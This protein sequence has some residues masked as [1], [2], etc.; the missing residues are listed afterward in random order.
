MIIEKSY[1]GINLSKC[2]TVGFYKVQIFLFLFIPFFCFGQNEPQYD[3]VTVFLKVPGI[4]GAD[5]PALIK[6][7]VAYLSISDVFTLLKIKNNISSRLDSLSGFFINPQDEYL[8]DKVKNQIIF[9]KKKIEL[10]SDDLIITETTLYMKT[11]LFGEVFGLNCQFNIRN[12]TIDLTTKL[13]LPTI[14]EMKMEQMRENLKR[15]RGEI[16]TD[17]TIGRSYPLFKFGM[18]DWIIN[19]SQQQGMSPSTQL[20]F[21]LGSMVA[22]G[23]MNMGLNYDQTNRF[24]LRQQ[25]YLW[26]YANNE[27][28]A[29]RQVLIGKML[30]QTI[31]SL[32]GS[33]VGIQLNNTPTV[34]RRSFGTYNLTDVTEPGWLVELYINN[35]LVDYVKA[36]A[37]GF[38]KFEVPLVY[39]NS[40]LKVRM[41]GPWG[42]IREKI[43]NANI[44]FNFLPQGELE[45]VTTA[46]VVE[47]QPNTK[48]SRTNVTYG[49]NHRISIGGGYEYFSS[50][51]IEN[52][53]P[54]VSS[55]IRVDN[56]LMVSGEYVLGTRLKSTLS[57]RLPS[58]L[59]L[60]LDYTGYEKDQK[61]IT[62]APIQE[63]G[64]SISIPTQGKKISTY[65]MLYLSQ[66]IYSNSQSTNALF[67]FSANLH[68]VSSNVT[69]SLTYLDTKHIN[70]TSNVSLSFLL[71]KRFLLRPSAQYDY[72]QRKWMSMKWQLDKPLF[73]KGYLNISYSRDFIN[74]VNN[75]IEIGL[76]YDCSFMQ[77]TFTSRINKNSSLYT[78]SANGSLLFDHKTHY[79]RASNNSMVGRAGLTFYAFLD[80]NGNGKRDNNEPKVFGLSLRVNG[81]RIL[82]HDK[83]STIRVIDLIPYTSY[84]VELNN[85]SFQNIA[86]KVK[87]AALTVYADPNQFKTIEIPVDVMSEATGTVSLKSKNGSKGLGRVYV[88][89]YRNDGSLFGRILTEGDGYYS[90]MGLKPGNYIARMDSSQLAKIKMTVSPEFKAFTVKSSK[91]GDFIEG[92]DFTLQSTVKDTTE[93]V[94]PK[95]KSI[96]I[97]PPTGR[98]ANIINYAMNTV[99][100]AEVVTSQNGQKRINATTLTQNVK[101]LPVSGRAD[102]SN[103]LT[104]YQNYQYSIESKQ[105]YS[106]QMGSYIFDA[107]ALAAQRKITAATGLPVV[108]V[109][110]DGF[111][112]LWID[113]FA[114]RKMAERFLKR[115][116]KMGFH[117]SYIIRGNKDITILANE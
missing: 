84:L 99:K 16:K 73:G 94:A 102:L 13:E 96:K 49:L 10:K 92:L 62:Y 19:T 29:L 81:G 65:S 30:Q 95:S 17:T 86:W 58:N 33:I 2:M 5:V 110:E 64:L 20:N 107:N 12:L 36:D 46:G 117:P 71:P 50:P 108:F 88:N 61:V 21:T 39:G 28:Q 15:L 35:V 80:M 104:N 44:P 66:W 41:Y 97:A 113:G 75:S 91:E 38:Y 77:T 6:N 24:D 111:I 54:F 48:F 34:F 59:Q 116:A 90:F 72:S 79:V 60:D 109:E 22:G 98:A 47:N 67:L 89:F 105:G 26:R 82:K 78:Q 101:S 63:R 45:Y 18:A 103:D 53:L 52:S 40:I 69:T 70:T 68:G 14:R 57:Y 93:G 9:Q 74:K 4:G 112:K 32:S 23:E 42:E 25:T 8:I 76:R 27:H 37:S 100:K 43:Q 55:S 106:I 7:N 3:E 56:N 1:T 11:N 85:N 51:Q 114:T 31:S 83:D 87:K 115:M